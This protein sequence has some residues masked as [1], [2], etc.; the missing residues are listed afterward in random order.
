[1]TEGLE[2]VKDA[3]MKQFALEHLTEGYDPDTLSSVI[4]FNAEGRDFSVRVSQE[5][6]D[7]YASGQLTVD[8]SQLRKVLRAAKDGKAVV[9]R[10]AILPG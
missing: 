8:L 2:A 7:D 10:D 5:F 1:M 9:R 3:I 4:G 6:D